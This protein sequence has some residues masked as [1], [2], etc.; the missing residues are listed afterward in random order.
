MGVIVGGGWPGE[1]VLPKKY[2]DAV[3]AHQ[4]QQAGHFGG[5]VPQLPYELPEPIQ[6]GLRV[7]F[8]AQQLVTTLI[9]GPVIKSA[10]KD[11]TRETWQLPAT[12]LSEEAAKEVAAAA[13]RLAMAFEAERERVMEA[14]AQQVPE[15]E[16]P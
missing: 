16:R 6:R 11:A 4:E 5:R 1:P 9:M 2:Q 12:L 8:H 7:Q 13:F 14:H 15:N 10:S 3:K